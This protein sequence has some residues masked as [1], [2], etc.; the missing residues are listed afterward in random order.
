MWIK[1]Q[2]QRVIISDESEDE[3]EQRSSRRREK[4]FSNICLTRLNS[5]GGG[6][7]IEVQDFFNISNIFQKFTMSPISKWQVLSLRCSWAV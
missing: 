2:P 3:I 1:K 6:T 7:E 4:S 5:F